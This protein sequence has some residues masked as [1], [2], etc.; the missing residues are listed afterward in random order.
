MMTSVCICYN[1]LNERIDGV[2]LAPM[3]LNEMQKS[4]GAN[5]RK[6]NVASSK[7][8]HHF[9]SSWLRYTRHWRRYNPRISSSHNALSP[10]ASALIWQNDKQGTFNEQN[11]KV[12]PGGGEF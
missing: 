8:L 11:V 4:A 6:I 7:G 5:R 9:N 2:Q 10:G 12:A 1:P 3:L